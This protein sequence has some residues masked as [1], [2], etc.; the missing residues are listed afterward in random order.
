MNNTVRV[1]NDKKKKSSRGVMCRELP[2]FANSSKGSLSVV[3]LVLCYSFNKFITG[4]FGSSHVI[5]N[6]YDIRII[7]KTMVVGKVTL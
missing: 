6:M 4:F 1:E 7:I 2:S 5:L 3:N